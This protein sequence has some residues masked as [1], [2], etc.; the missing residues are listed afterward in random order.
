MRV[1]VE[2]EIHK[3]SRT[4]HDHDVDFQTPLFFGAAGGS[5]VW[6]FEINRP[7]PLKR[8]SNLCYSKS[9]NVNF[10]GNGIHVNGKYTP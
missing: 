7:L 9:Q 3:S 1:F 6:G 4:K 10:I 8:M 2:E 5:R